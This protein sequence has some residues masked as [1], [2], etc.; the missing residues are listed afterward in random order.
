MTDISIPDAS[1]SEKET[2]AIQVTRPRAGVSLIEIKSE[3]L[4]VLRIAV[5][6][7]LRAALAGL[8]SDPQ[9][10]CVVLTGTGRAFSAGSDIR[11]FKRDAGWLLAA[12]N[13]EN[14]LNDFIEASRLPV[15]AACN[16]VT[17]GGGAVLS[18]AC[19]IR[20]AARSAR[21]GFPEVRVAAL[22]S[23]SGSQ[24][25]PRLVG[26]G[27]AMELLLTGRIF[28]AEEALRIGL[29]QEVAP[30]D[31]LIERALELAGSIAELPA[32]A[33]A[34]TKKCVYTGLK[35]GYAAGLLEE[36]RLS[37]EMGLTDDAAEGQ[38]AF[39]EK[40]PPNFGKDRNLVDE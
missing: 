27:R 16:G 40:R 21:F 22:P 33:I 23:G 6:N 24:R 10:N 26:L 13:A 38:R 11:D 2:S 31:R 14:G 39:L 8:A 15:I 1:Y 18:L 35:E 29:V 5:K 4:G 28:D 30:D 7:A 32:L 34:A 17:L 37:V 9:V 19:D 36:M 25:L 12:E 20:I 3:P